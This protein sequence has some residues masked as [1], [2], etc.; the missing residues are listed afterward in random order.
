MCNDDKQ[1]LCVCAEFSLRKAT[2]SETALLI[3]LWRKQSRDLTSLIGE[4]KGLEQSVD[5]QGCL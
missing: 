5:N 2:V 3:P 4:M 1:H